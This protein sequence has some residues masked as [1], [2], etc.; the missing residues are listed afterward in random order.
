MEN[1]NDAIFALG[2]IIAIG[3]FYSIGMY[4]L[5]RSEPKS[6]QQNKDSEMLK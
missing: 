6:T 5:G 2:G 3:S 1:I 4:L